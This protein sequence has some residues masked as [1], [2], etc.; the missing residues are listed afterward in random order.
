MVEPMKLDGLGRASD[1]SGIHVCVAGIRVAGAACV[2][3]LVALGADVVA[4]D[5]G[6]SADHE[7]WADELR[8]IGATVRLGDGDTLPT[9]LDLL[10]VSP[11]FPPTAPI[12][13]SA[14][15]AG[16][17]VWG[18]L[19]LAWR[20][21]SAQ[22][23]PWL[24]I[25]GTNG[26]TTATL[27]LE[28]ILR[29]AGQRAI[30][31]ANIGVSLV[32]A[33]MAD[34]LDVIAVEVGAPQ[35]PFWHSVSPLA[36]VCL[37]VAE[38]HIDHFGSFDA[39]TAA[40][41]RIYER[42]QVA[43]I[44]NCADQRTIAM[45]RDADVAP[46]CRAI[47]FTLGIPGPGELGV[48]EELL[49]DRAF[50][51]DR[52]TTAVE[53]AVVDDV[54]PAAAHNVANALSA[55]ALARAFGVSPEAIAAGLRSFTPAGH[56]IADVAEVRGVRYIDDSKATNA[57][58]ADTSLRSYES[59]VWIAGGLAKGQE[60]DEL[61]ATSRDRLRA[62]ILLGA[63]REVIAGALQR[64]APEVPVVVVANTQTGAMAEVVAAAAA[65]AEP[66]DTVLLAPGCASWDMFVSYAQRG[67]MFAQEVHRLA[68]PT[69]E[70][71]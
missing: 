45:V 44:Y 10:V 4:V 5:A 39:Y 48:V 70:H 15:A 34:D 2:R 35:L 65:M 53:L 52:D 3:A 9:D 68:A 18:E 69:E 43:A 67:D 7:R 37:N 64:H 19:E 17:T 28:S 62:V 31:A 16:V 60:F 47:G 30:A 14:T 61:V 59:V 22:A 36:A 20:L 57:H 8:S 1:W 27:M 46:G 58:A 51:A 33:V 66:G 56:R 49:V 24:A 32:E 26:K 41:A 40:K 63:D 6:A 42:C 12:I 11:G 71:R 13:R 38:D 21:R 25:T 29:A 23:A 54:H 50:G 55:A